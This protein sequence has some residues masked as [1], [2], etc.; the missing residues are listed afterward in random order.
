MSSPVRLSSVTFVHPTQ[1][2]EVFGNLSTPFGTLA[3]SELSV[4]ILQRSSQGNPSVGGGVNTKGVAKY[5]N[6]GPFEG[7][8]LETMQDI[9]YH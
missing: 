5:S 9:S 3:I 2:T 7:Y 6:F 8:I 1:A 4:K